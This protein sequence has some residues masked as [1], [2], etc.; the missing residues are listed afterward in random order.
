M[1]VWR[2]ILKKKDFW[3]EANSFSFLEESQEFFLTC[4][5][6]N[7]LNPCLFLS[8]KKRFCLFFW[9]SLFLCRLVVS[10]LFLLF[11][12]SFTQ[13]VPTS[14]FTK[15]TQISSIEGQGGTS[16]PKEELT[17]EEQNTA[18]TLDLSTGKTFVFY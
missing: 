7:T 8:Q 18:V 6:T 9:D 15:Y 2:E 17:L 1:T 10:V 16:D 4:P 13:L 14:I 5:L 12:F 3:S 11:I